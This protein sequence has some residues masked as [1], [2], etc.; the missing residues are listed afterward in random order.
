MDFEAAPLSRVPIV[1]LVYG[2]PSSALSVILWFPGQ[3]PR[4]ARPIPDDRQ[5]E[6]SDWSEMAYERTAGF[7]KKEAST[8]HRG[9]NLGQEKAN[10]KMGEG[11]GGAFFLPEEPFDRWKRWANRRLV[12][13]WSANVSQRHGDRK[14]EPTEMAGEERQTGSE[15]WLRRPKIPG[16]ERSGWQKSTM[17]QLQD[18]TW[19]SPQNFCWHIERV[20]KEEIIKTWTDKRMIV[21]TTITSTSPLVLLLLVH[22][23][24]MNQPTTSLAG[25]TWP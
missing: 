11:I 7:P 23:P 6:P 19:K 14:K 20:G 18:K 10:R 24:W 13:I 17:P 22:T 9:S 16:K 5:R 3:L 8:R 12:K 25:R 2:I 4:F 1:L 15:K 21:P